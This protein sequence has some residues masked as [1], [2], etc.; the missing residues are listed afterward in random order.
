MPFD[1][2]TTPSNTAPEVDDNNTLE[3]LVLARTLVNNGWIKGVT[4]SR[5][6]IPQ[7]K[8]TRYC[9]VGAYREAFT[10]Y[11]GIHNGADMSITADLMIAPVLYKETPWRYRFVQWLAG[12]NEHVSIKL[13]MLNDHPATRHQVI[14]KLYDKAIANQRKKGN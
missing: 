4:A 12:R 11:Y 5:C 13:M 2:L 6:N 3:V 9:A 10:R 14:V 1:A 8:Y 7:H